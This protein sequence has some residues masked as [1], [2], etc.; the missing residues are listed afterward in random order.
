ME[1]MIDHLAVSLLSLY[2]ESSFNEVCAGCVREFAFAGKRCA[3]GV[4]ENAAFQGTLKRNTE[5]AHKR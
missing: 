2:Q 4:C 5:D 1:E 3:R